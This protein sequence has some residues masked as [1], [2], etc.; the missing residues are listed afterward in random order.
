MTHNHGN[1]TRLSGNRI[2]RDE[3]VD[4]EG[5]PVINMKPLK[6]KAK[7]SRKHSGGDEQEANHKLLEK[8]IH[9]AC[10]KEVKCQA[11]TI[12]RSLGLLSFL[13]WSAMVPCNEER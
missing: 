7:R 9:Q 11:T 10:G 6:M 5:L 12:Q 8:R 4:E 2:Q 1:H 3:D 13:R